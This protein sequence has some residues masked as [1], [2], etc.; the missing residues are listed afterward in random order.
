MQPTA[1]PSPA[2]AWQQRRSR[3]EAAGRRSRHLPARRACSTESSSCA[4]CLATEPARSWPLKGLDPAT[5][6]GAG[7][8]SLGQGESK[9]FFEESRAAAFQAELL[10]LPAGLGSWGASF[11]AGAVR[12]QDSRVI[13]SRPL[14]TSLPGRERRERR[15]RATGTHGVSLCAGLASA[16]RGPG[17]CCAAEP[18][19]TKA[20][21]TASPCTA[22][23]LTGFFPP[24]P[25]QY[26][27]NVSALVHDAWGLGI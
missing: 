1:S 14:V 13:L 19:L 26:V 2:I 8:I 15:R 20:R 6:R 5:G 21:A 24:E 3:A 22:L 11:R 10:C 12:S 25:W 16:A 27:F 17:E 4:L 9:T 7:P 23:L 18:G